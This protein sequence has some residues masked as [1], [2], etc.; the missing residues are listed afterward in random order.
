MKKC[1]N[2]GI[3]RKGSGSICGHGGK[4]RIREMRHDAGDRYLDFTPVMIVAGAAIVALR[5]VALGMGGR[6][7]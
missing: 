6:A 7:M 4:R 1:P 3:V 2:C 5:Y